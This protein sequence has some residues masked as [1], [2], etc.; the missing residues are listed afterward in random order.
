MNSFHH[1]NLVSPT[2][3]ARDL[4]SRH[5]QARATPTTVRPEPFP[6]GSFS[7]AE[8]SYAMKDATIYNA[9][10]RLPFLPTSYSQFRDAGP[11]HLRSAANYGFQLKEEDYTTPHPGEL[12]QGTNSQFISMSGTNPLFSTDRSFLSS[13]GQGAL[14]TTFSPLPFSSINR[15]QNLPHT[16]R[17]TK[18][19]THM[20]EVMEASGLSE[21][22]ELNLD[23]PW[24]INGAN[25]DLSF[26][27]GLTVDNPQI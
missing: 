7:H 26:P 17:E 21:E 4:A 11:D 27:H 15:Q 19:Q 1:S 2:P 23:G 12:A 10:S 9:S 24:G 22:Q 20:C 16:S 5:P 3:Q 25:S 14:D 6:P 18:Q 8:A 13:Y